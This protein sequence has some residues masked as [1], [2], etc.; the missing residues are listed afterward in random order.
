MTTAATHNPALARELLI[1]MIAG[2]SAFQTRGSWA[3]ATAA[4]A[5]IH[6]PFVAGEADARAGSSALERP[7]ALIEVASFDYP[8]LRT[9]GPRWPVGSFSVLLT[10]WHTDDE[11]YQSAL[12]DFENFLGGVMQDLADAASV[13]TNLAINS[14]TL[15]AVA[16]Q[17][18][19]V[20]TQAPYWAAKFALD[21]GTLGEGE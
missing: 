8:D 14:M 15:E 19:L 1:D 10:D 7:A 2:S 13:G 17:L 6:Y 11:D 21:W 20:D 5:G 4:L 9:G 12:V 18:S 3:N 16:Q